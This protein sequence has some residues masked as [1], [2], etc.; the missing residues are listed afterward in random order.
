[1]GFKRLELGFAAICMGF[2]Q[3]HHKTHVYSS[4]NHSETAAQA[5]PYLQLQGPARGRISSLTH[6]HS[7]ASPACTNESKSKSISRFRGY[8]QYSLP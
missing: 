4:K 8:S 2:K 5:E 7:F 1:M 3:Y 6:S